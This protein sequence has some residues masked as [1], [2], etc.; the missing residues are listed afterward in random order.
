MRRGVG[1]RVGPWCP[2][3]RWRQTGFGTWTAECPSPSQTP[4][5]RWRAGGSSAPAQSVYQQVF[6]NVIPFSVG[7]LFHRTAQHRPCPRCP[8]AALRIAVGSLVAH[9][10]LVTLA[11][12][13]SL[14]PWMDATQRQAGCAQRM[15]KC[16]TSHLRS[17]DGSR[18][19]DSRGQRAR[20]WDKA[21]GTTDANF[22]PPPTPHTVYGQG[23]REA[24]E[25]PR[26]HGAMNDGGRWIPMSHV[27]CSSIAVLASGSRLGICC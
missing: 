8:A 26:N 27:R 14:G 12:A 10:R 16:P 25:C 15:R 17:L 19:R 23:N 13:G 2:L 21:M 4:W 1:R 18:S 3:L 11:L 5:S 9:H 24:A 22:T 20:Q 6:R 7:R